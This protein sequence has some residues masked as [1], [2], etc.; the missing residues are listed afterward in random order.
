MGLAATKME[1]VCRELGCNWAGEI[2][3]DRAYNDDA[4]LVDR[5]KP[6]SVLTDAETAAPRILNMLKSGGIITESGKLIPC[7]ID[8]IC[9]HGDKPSAVAMARGVRDLLTDAGI[10]VTRF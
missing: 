6:G 10:N 4:T 8:T 9:V 5:S 7:K 3:A 1:D 2:F